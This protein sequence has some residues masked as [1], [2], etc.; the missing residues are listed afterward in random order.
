MVDEGRSVALEGVVCLKCHWL[1][2]AAPE[3]KDAPSAWAPDLGGARERLRPDWVRAWL[4][5]PALKYPGTAMAVNFGSEEPLYQA[6]FPD[7]TNAGQ[8]E[9]V[10]DW[11]YTLDR[12]ESPAKN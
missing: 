5:N 11:L 1:N 6:Q 9:A 4:W 12:S 3:Q 2:D 8:I 7:S 10:L